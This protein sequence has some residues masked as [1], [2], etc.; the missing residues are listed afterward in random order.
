MMASEFPIGIVEK[1]NILFRYT[2]DLTR[3]DCLRVPSPP[4]FGFAHELPVRGCAVGHER[5]GYPGASISLESNGSATTKR[6]VVLMRGKD[7][8][9]ARLPGS[10]LNLQSRVEQAP[11]CLHL[12]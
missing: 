3:I 1:P 2:E 5:H 6:F 10:Q 11:Q 9:R 8:R 7:Q 12:P 4:E